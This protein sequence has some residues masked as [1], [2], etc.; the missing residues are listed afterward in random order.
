MGISRISRAIVWLL[1]FWLPWSTAFPQLT[2][3][4][5]QHAESAIVRL[6][7]GDFPD[8]PAD[9]RTVLEQ[10]G[11]TVPQPYNAGVQKRNVVSGQFTAVGQTEWA[12]LCS[13]EKRSAI[14]VFR[15][16]HPDQVDRLAEEADAQYLQVV[17][18]EREI[19]YSRQL[20]VASPKLVRRRFSKGTLRTADHDGIENIFL[21]KASVVW[22]RS[23]GK[24]ISTPA[25][26]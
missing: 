17:H 16:A 15:G 21:G 5:W 2:K 26:D 7:P 3:E 13:H 19:G 24:W 4:D 12:V 20:T 23:G 14:L 25:G 10:R 1:F 11:C 6:G 9:V 18:G 8:L 22:Y